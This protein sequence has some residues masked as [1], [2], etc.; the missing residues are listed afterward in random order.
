VITSL[1]QPQGGMR[2]KKIIHKIYK[3]KENPMMKYLSF[4]MKAEGF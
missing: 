3:K 2:M 1:L 4:K